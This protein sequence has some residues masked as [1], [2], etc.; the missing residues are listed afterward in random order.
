MSRRE[1]IEIVCDR[2]GKTEIKL[3]NKVAPEIKKNGKGA[4]FHARIWVPGKGN[5]NVS[6]DDLCK[7][8]DGALQNY[9][10]KI[11]KADQEQSGEE[12]EK[13]PEKKPGLLGKKG[14]ARAAS[15]S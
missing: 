13:K 8:C 3:K 15:T 11:K 9:F 6:Y 7:R 1:V 12:P 10:D 5:K 2:C 14:G 4:A